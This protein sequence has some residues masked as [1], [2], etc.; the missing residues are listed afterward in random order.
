MHANIPETRHVDRLIRTVVR[1]LEVTRV[2]PHGV[3]R[4]RKLA[5]RQELECHFPS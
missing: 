3:M 4:I 1:A 2:F 5:D